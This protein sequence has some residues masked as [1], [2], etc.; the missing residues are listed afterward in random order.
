M[1]KHSSYLCDSLLAVDSAPVELIVSQ[2]PLSSR[3]FE[4][5]FE[6]DCFSGFFIATGGIGFLKG[7]SLIGCC[8]D[9]S[10]LLR[11]EFG[12]SEIPKVV[13]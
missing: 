10:R 4:F 13:S 6:F 8:G 5:I 11:F 1:L 3:M 2:L 9:G 7:S 12:S